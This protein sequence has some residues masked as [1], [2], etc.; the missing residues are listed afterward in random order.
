MNSFLVLLI[1]KEF[2]PAAQYCGY[3]ELVTVF[4]CVPVHGVGE[5]VTV[6][7]FW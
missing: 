7:V 2:L 4:S 3:L 5:C 6:S 1:Q